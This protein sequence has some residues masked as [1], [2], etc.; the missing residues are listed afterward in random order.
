MHRLPIIN[1]FSVHHYYSKDTFKTKLT[2]LWRIYNTAQ[3]TYP[4]RHDELRSNPPRRLLLCGQNPV[5][6]HDRRGRQVFLLYSPVP[7]RQKS[8]SKYVATLL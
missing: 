7:F 8:Y 3:K 4:I 1:R 6:P 5:Y 2:K